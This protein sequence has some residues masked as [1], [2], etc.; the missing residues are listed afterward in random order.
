MRLVVEG[1]LTLVVFLIFIALLPKSAERTKPIH[2]R[3]DYFSEKDRRIMS[4]RVTAVANSA[5][6]D[7]SWTNVKG[8][9]L[10][11]RLWLHM[12]ISKCRCAKCM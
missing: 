6:A 5:K 4:G 2:G 10:D 7:L 8:A 9:F 12:A 11:Y 3:F 1:M